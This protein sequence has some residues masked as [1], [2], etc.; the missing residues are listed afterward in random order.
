[1]VFLVQN[2]QKRDGVA[3]QIKLDEIILSVQGA[4]NTL[5]DLEEATDAEIEQARQRFNKIAETAKNGTV[6]VKLRDVGP[7]K[8]DASRLRPDKW[9]PELRHK[10]DVDV[11]NSLLLPV[12]FSRSP[13]ASEVIR[14]G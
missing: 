13:C 7:P 4:S 11:R 5:I 14:I 8:K 2:S 10:F 1:M 6:K 9:Q 12:S 3:I